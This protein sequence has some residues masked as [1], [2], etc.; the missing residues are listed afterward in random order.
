M[1][2]KSAGPLSPPA[3]QLPSPVSLPY[4]PPPGPPDNNRH[5]HLNKAS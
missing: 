2:R 1:S 5:P 3:P 4:R